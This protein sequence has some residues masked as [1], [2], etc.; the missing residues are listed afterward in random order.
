MPKA[1]V[2]Y[3]NPGPLNE[4]LDRLSGP[5]YI[6][7]VIQW[8]AGLRVSEAMDLRREDIDFENKSLTVRDGKGGKGRTVPLH[9]D[10][11]QLLRS[12]PKPAVGQ[13]FIGRGRQGRPIAQ[14]TIYRAYR[15]AG[16][17]ST[18]VLRHSFARHLSAEGRPMNEIQ[19]ILGHAYLTTT[20]ETYLPI[21]NV[22]P[23]AL[24]DIP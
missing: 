8:R 5:A 7:A 11:N 24:D 6:A 10:L 1:A 14:S 21:T 17:D 20:A 13:T 23:G 19:L 2:K 12:L 9:K 4:A 16:I 3:M 15:K 18:H 22:A